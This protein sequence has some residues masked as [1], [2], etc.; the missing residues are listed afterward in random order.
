MIP[1]DRKRVVDGL[2]Q[3]VHERLCALE[4]AE[5]GEPRLREPGLL[6]DFAPGE[7]PPDL[8]AVAT[9]PE[10][11]T[12]LHEQALAPF[13]EETRNER[14]AVIEPIGAHVEL[15]LTELLQRADE[16]IGRAA[17]EVEEKVPGAEGPPAQAGARHGELLSRR[18][19][20]RADLE[21]QRPPTLQAVERLASALV[22]PH[23]ARE[24]P[25][26]RRFGPNFETEAF[27]VTQCETAPQ[28]EEPVPDPAR[29]PWREVRKVAHYYLT[30]DALQQ[31]REVREDAPPWGGS[32]P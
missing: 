8:P 1:K 32:E 7:P 30:V 31:P 19:R 5:G 15:S 20:R 4:M 22:L 3:V 10:A 2:G 12:W 29:L 14:L 24:A 17:A 11:T 6:G 25:E 9:L 28:L 23:P 21:R 13:L 27:V 16:E 26:V 18:E